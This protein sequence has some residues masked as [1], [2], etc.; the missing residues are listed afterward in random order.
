MWNAESESYLAAVLDVITLR[1][2]RIAGVT[3]FLAPW[4]FRRFGDIPGRMTPEVFRSFGLPDA[5]R[6]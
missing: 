4:V 6:A 2:T 3:G 5:L 1:G